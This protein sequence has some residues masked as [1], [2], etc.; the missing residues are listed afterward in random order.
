LT[1]GDGYDKIEVV[2]NQ[3]DDKHIVFAA[4]GLA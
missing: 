2:I 3:T 4:E 1:T